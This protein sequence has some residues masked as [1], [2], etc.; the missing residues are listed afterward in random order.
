MLSRAVSALS[1]LKSPYMV[2]AQIRAGGRGKAGAIKAAYS[3]SEAQKAV[4][5][6]LGAKVKDLTVNELLI[7]EKVSV[8]KELYLDWWLIGSAV[9]TFCY[10][11]EWAA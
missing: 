4:S 2:K 5:E 9:A 11:H 6:L 10:P 1:D 7:E 3:T 8:K